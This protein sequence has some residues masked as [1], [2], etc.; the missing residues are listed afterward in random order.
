MCLY[1]QSRWSWWARWSCRSLR[2]LR[3][4]AALWKAV[5]FNTKACSKR[6]IGVIFTHFFT[7]EPWRTISSS[8]A[9]N[10]GLTLKTHLHKIT[11]ATNNTVSCIKET[12][13]IPVVLG[14]LAVLG[15]PWKTTGIYIHLFMVITLFFLSGYE[16]SLSPRWHYLHS[17]D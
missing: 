1:H 6:T 4:I 17:W 16:L 2:A 8:L 9:S 10:T 13:Y 3:S 12:I 11:Q 14:I 15:N 7:F 5:N